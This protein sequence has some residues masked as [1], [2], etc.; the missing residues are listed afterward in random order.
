[1]TLISGRSEFHAAVHNAERYNRMATERKRNITRTIKYNHKK[2]K[3][4]Q[5]FP[6]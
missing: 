2:I 6:F 4:I 5:F 3:P 1:M